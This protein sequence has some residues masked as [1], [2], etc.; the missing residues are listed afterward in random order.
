MFTLCLDPGHG[1]SEPGA[2]RDG[3]KEADLTLRIAVGAEKHLRGKYRIVLTREA[4]RTVS[5]DQRRVTAD[6]AKADLFVSIHI[7]SAGN[8]GARGYEVFVRRKPSPESL[9]LGSAMLVQFSRR[10]PNRP[11]RGLKHA[12][13]RVLLQP[14][15]ACLVEC[16]FISNPAER[17]TL[18][19][20]KGVA[21]LSE[22]IA[23]ACGNFVKAILGPTSM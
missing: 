8:A 14:R 1:G 17:H 4:D 9:V 5:L 18:T 20:Q 11:N 23:W 3:L 21:Q 10:W 22:A 12:N 7:N 6:R 15:P 2:I 13:F 19:D 16:F